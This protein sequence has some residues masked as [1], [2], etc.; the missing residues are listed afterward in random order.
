MH[1]FDPESDWNKAYSSLVDLKACASCQKE[2]PYNMFR[3]DSSFRDGRKPQ[4][5]A[6]AAVPRL[7]T[8]EH[9]HRQREMNLRAAGR[10]RWEHQS[11]WYDDAARTLN[12]L[13]QN[14]VIRRLQKLIPNLYFT[15]GRIYGDVSVY[16]TY[17][18]GQPQLGGNSF[19]YLMYIPGGL[20]PEFSVM[21]FDAKNVPVKEAQR[22]WRTILLRLIKSKLVTEQKAHE[23]FGEPRGLGSASYRRQLFDWRSGK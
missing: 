9:T 12:Y 8:I 1:D 21:E 15:D 20:M 14:E 19:E 3:K 4:C 17:G 13:S 22:G 2:L 16:R 10:Q 6:C 5:D 23:A 7:S 18:Q 11:E